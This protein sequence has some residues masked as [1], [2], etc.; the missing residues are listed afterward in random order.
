MRPFVGVSKDFLKFFAFIKILLKIF[1]ILCVCSDS[2]AYAEHTHQELMR[3][4]ICRRQQETRALLQ[5]FFELQ[6]GGFIQ[7]QKNSSYIASIIYRVILTKTADKRYM[8]SRDFN[9][10]C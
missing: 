5:P 3:M 2:Y 6:V 7:Q 4:L 8:L 10:I 1:V 9:K